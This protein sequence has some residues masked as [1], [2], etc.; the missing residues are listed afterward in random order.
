MDKAHIT[1]IRRYIIKRN[2]KGKLYFVLETKG[3]LR[4]DDLRTPERQKIHCGRRHFE[5]V[6]IRYKKNKHKPI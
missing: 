5:A 6:V 1:P 2:G 3:A 4:F